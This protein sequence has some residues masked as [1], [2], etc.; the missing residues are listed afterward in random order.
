MQDVSHPLA[1]CVHACL[2]LPVSG[3][4][5]TLDANL[6]PGDL[7]QSFSAS[8]YGCFASGNSSPDEEL[9]SY[10]AVI[11]GHP[12]PNLAPSQMGEHIAG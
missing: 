11:P 4:R 1:T 8:T 10:L 3:G 7:D 2:L 9:F 6:E 5:D 12:V